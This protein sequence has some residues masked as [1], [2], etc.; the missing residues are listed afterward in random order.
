MVVNCKPVDV[1]FPA[2]FQN[3][4]CVTATVLG[5][6]GTAVVTNATATGFTIAGGAAV[7]VVDPGTFAPAVRWQ[8]MGT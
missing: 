8:A 4:P 2:S 7:F 6:P 5:Y 3:R 1:L